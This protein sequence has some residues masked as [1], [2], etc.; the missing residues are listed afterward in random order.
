M[1]NTACLAN[2]IIAYQLDLDRRISKV[3]RARAAGTVDASAGLGG[4]VGSGVSGNDAVTATISDNTL[5]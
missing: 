5:R 3:I 1:L 4:G 2:I